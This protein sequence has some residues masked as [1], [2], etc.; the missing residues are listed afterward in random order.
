MEKENSPPVAPESA[1]VSDDTGQAKKDG[2]LNRA[3]N[4][5]DML[6]SLNS[7]I[8][9]RILKRSTPIKPVDARRDRSPSS[10][11]PVNGSPA[12]PPSTPSPGKNYHLLYLEV[13]KRLFEQTE[14]GNKRYLE[15]E[16][17]HKELRRKYKEE[18]KTKD[19]RILNLQTKLGQITESRDEE[20]AD[21]DTSL[22]G[23]RKVIMD[24]EKCMA[25]MEEKLQEKTQTNSVEKITG[26]HRIESEESIFRLKPTPKQKQKQTTNDELACDFADCNQKD[27]DLIQCN[28]CSKWVCGECNDIPVAKCKPIFNKCRTIYFLC[29]TCDQRIGSQDEPPHVSVGNVDAP[30]ATPGNADLITSLQKMLDKKVSQ[31]ESKIEKS[32]EKKLGDK[33]DAV[34]CL[35]DKIKEQ[36]KQA[37]EEKTSYAKILNVPK[38]VRKIIQETRNDE[39]VNQIEQE[40]RCQN[41]IIHGADEIGD[42]E[43][44]IKENDK[45][46]VADILEHMEIEATPESVVRLGK[47]NEKKGRVMKITMSTKAFKEEVMANVRRL[48]DTAETFGKISV[49]DDYTATERQQIQDFVKKARE[50]GAQDTSRVFKVRGDPKNGLRIMSYKKT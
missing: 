40:K 30:P 23:L 19:A 42:N 36:E 24:N 29:K 20:R 1:D 11:G 33:L 16:A 6:E 34:T 21:H 17:A 10:P 3:V 47:T 41:F 15:L 32:I 14:A 22:Q 45:K 4:E 28:M 8:P 25:E 18:T 37:S 46:Y 13:T 48:K 5:N 7:P 35:T 2:D 49:T 38:E 43:D 39:K 27:V 50:Q 9:I 12:T 31:L 26:L 44:E